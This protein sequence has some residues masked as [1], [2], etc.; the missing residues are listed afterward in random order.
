[1]KVVM[2]ISDRVTV[3]DHGEKIAEGT[4]EEVRTRPA[5]HRGLSRG[6]RAHDDRARRA[7]AHGRGAADRPATPI[8][9]LD[10]V[11]TY[12]GHIHALRGINLEVY[13]GEI[14]TLIGANGAG[15]TTT[16]KTISG[17][18][19]PR[20]GNVEFNGKDVSKRAAHDLVRAG[21]RPRPRRAPDLLAA[22]GPREP[23]DGRVHPR[24]KAETD[25]DLEQVIDALPAAE[26][27]LPASRAARCRAAS[28]RCWPSAG[29]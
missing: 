12:Y 17:L 8:L 23:P 18:L 1:M 26:G 21:H 5:R 25:D 22:D 19:H 29:R 28:S 9:R 13:R 27:A 11:N 2:G 3:L 20:R 14:V 7:P 10:D 4:P 24:P 16:L 6:S 15:K